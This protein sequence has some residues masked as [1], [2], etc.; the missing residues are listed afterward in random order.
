MTPAVR[1][2]I[3]FLC[4]TVTVGPGRGLSEPV[5]FR[6]C[7]DLNVSDTTFYLP[8]AMAAGFQMAERHITAGNCTYMDAI[9]HECQDLLPIHLDVSIRNL[10][11]QP[12]DFLAAVAAKE[13]TDFDADLMLL[14]PD[15][16]TR[17]LVPINAA[18]GIVTGAAALS[19]SPT[20]ASRVF[21]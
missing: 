19:Q 4:V 14:G 18:N 11:L 2:W 3:L 12:D 1:C 5:A 9:Y 6:T 8:V 16:Q 21:R 10:P 17:T 13:C 15:S 20:D 7:L